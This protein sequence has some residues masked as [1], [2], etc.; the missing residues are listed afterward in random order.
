MLSLRNIKLVKKLWLIIG[1]A[2][3]GVVLL[4]SMS[5][6]FL[7]HDLLREKEHDSRRLVEGAHSIINFYYMMAQEGKIHEQEAKSIAIAA[8]RAMANN[9][10]EYLWINDMHPHIIMHPI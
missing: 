1:S 9:G 10:S 7:D 8:V 4:I 3:A 6:I 5:L 2:L